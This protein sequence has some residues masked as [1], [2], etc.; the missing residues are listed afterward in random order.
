MRFILDYKYYR[1]GVEYV[2][3]SGRTNDSAHARTLRLF[4]RA[5]SGLLPDASHV[6]RDAPPRDRPPF[7]KESHAHILRGGGVN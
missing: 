2:H 1:I 7:C 3:D 5:R 4:R 6:F